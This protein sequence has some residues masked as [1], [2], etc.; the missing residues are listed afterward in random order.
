MKKTGTVPLI[1][2][3]LAFSFSCVNP[4]GDVDQ[5]LAI[6]AL[7]GVVSIIGVAEAERT[8][9]ADINGI[10]NAHGDP[11]YVWRRGTT[12]IGDSPTCRL[13]D[14]DVG[15]PVTVTVSFSESGGSVT[16]LPTA[17]VAAQRPPENRSEG[18]YP[19]N[20]DTPVS[21]D[22]YTGTF[23]EKAFAY[24]NDD[25]HYDSVYAVVLGSDVN[26]PPVERFSYLTLEK[27]GVTVML[28]GSVREQI[29]SSN[30]SGALFAVEAGTLALG[31]NITITGSAK[32]AS[33]GN[34]GILIMER[35]AKISVNGPYSSVD[36]HSGS[37]FFMYG[38]EI[39]GNNYFSESDPLAL[40]Y[41]KFGGAV[42]AIGGNFFMS[43]GEISGNYA[44]SSGGAIAVTNGTCVL[45]GDAVIC[46][47]S[48]VAGGAIEVQNS[49]RL[50]ISG[51]V[52]IRGNTATMGGAIDI[53][54]SSFEKRGGSISGNIATKQD[55]GGHQIRVNQ[56]ASAD[57]DLYRD[58][59]ISVSENC[60]VERKGSYNFDLSPAKGFWA[61]YPTM[62][63]GL[64]IPEDPYL[65][66]TETEFRA[67]GTG[68]YGYD[69]NYLLCAGMTVAAPRPGPFTG[70]F[71]GNGKK[72]TL[73]I[74]TETVPA[75]AA[76]RLGLFSVLNGATVRNMAVDGV[77]NAQSSG[78]IY[79]GAAAGQA[80]N[81]TIQ[82]LASRV[83][84]TANS[85]GGVRAG[86]IAGQAFD[87]TVEDSYSTGNI[88]AHAAG[89]AYSGGLIGNAGDSASGSR[90]TINR[91]FASGEIHAE[92]TGAG[93]YSGGILSLVNAGTTGALNNCAALNSGIV[94]V[95]RG[96][97]ISRGRIVNISSSVELSNN[98][99]NGGMIFNPAYT[100]A[101]NASGQDGAAVTQAALERSWWTE[102]LR[103][104]FG[105]ARDAPWSWGGTV[106]KLWFE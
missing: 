41:K 17:P 27:G 62:L 77:I 1:L 14:G 55:G 72:V 57:T 59:A 16:S 49:S 65:I 40:L 91:C 97:N 5:S 30:H 20:G 86:G 12:A 54:D 53:L 95:T 9:M 100:P 8:L 44:G 56:F 68:N 79:A 46:G 18:L 93:A 33:A 26:I 96:G 31:E 70:V 80:Y 82:A 51:S 83:F 78:D 64:G 61:K 36:T 2:L 19:G 67:I 22:G 13:S 75:E 10:E 66:T 6:P 23:I 11:S 69:K 89:G 74:N 71:D 3:W 38:G 28:R 25:A 104:P 37:T 81:S 47:N 99:A 90:V 32:A 7:S 85:G 84:I 21:V 45:T 15:F 52:E 73:N 92:S 35:G 39:T 58:A 94:T 76:G 98:Y 106:P 42:F 88:T 34:G 24:I 50:S 105:S 103:W 101:N 102:T 43:G 60:R 4:A 29:I 87:L 63:E 48:A